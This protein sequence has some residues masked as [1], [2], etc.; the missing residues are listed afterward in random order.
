MDDN[1]YQDDFEELLQDQVRNQRMY[2]SDAVWR[3]I[4]KELHG[5]TNWPALTIS[6]FALLIATVA[7][8]I[9]FSPKP[10]IFAIPAGYSQKMNTG[11]G[12]Q[13]ANLSSPSF[14]NHPKS[15]SVTTTSNL[16]A[17]HH[18]NAAANV[19]VGAP[20]IELR[21]NRRSESTVSTALTGGLAKV[22]PLSQTPN[23]NEG[24]SEVVSSV[25]SGKP[26]VDEVSSPVFQS[27]SSKAVNSAPAPLSTT[28]AAAGS[29]DKNIVDNFLKEHANDVSLYTT[30]QPKVIRKRFSYVA[31]VAPSVSYRK[32]KEDRSG[33]N[34]NT[35]AGGPVALNYVTDVNKVVRHKP[36]TGL[37]AGF[38]VIYNLSDKLRIRSG[39][40]FNI[41]QYN[42]EAYR[43]SGERAGIALV[44]GNRID[45]IYSSS[46]YRT[47]NGLVSAELANRY[48]QVAIPLGLEWE[49]VGNKNIQLNIAGSI[50]PTYLLNKNAYLLSTN[51]KNY[52][53]SRGMVNSWNLN[54]NI[55]T[56]ISFKVG[57]Y[58]WQVGPQ[59]R[60]QHFSTFI[61]PYPIKE[62]LMDYGFKLGVSKIIL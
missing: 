37:E 11:D 6:A 50:Q 3:N 32:L 46:V 34:D 4:N 26:I 31:Y 35:G 53:E 40:Q 9:H 59:L 49:I 56:F 5:D 14:L 54:S 18:A 44:S 8:C 55:E 30:T 58:K 23:Y 29:N 39:L 10:N 22:I 45:T 2:P 62:H 27:G 52:T 57:D 24:A 16:K 28:P 51:Y 41:R 25:P 17:V 20:I 61:S 7:V 43:S 38:G 19:S 42:I 60:Y 1:L 36:G 15:S 12:N 33:L 21:S 13:I 48:Y 47:N